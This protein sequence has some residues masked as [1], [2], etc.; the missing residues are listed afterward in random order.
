MTSSSLYVSVEP[1]QTRVASKIITTSKEV[2]RQTPKW[3]FPIG[4]PKFNSSLSRVIR[5][6]SFE[7][8]DRWKYLQD[9]ERAKKYRKL[10]CLA[11]MLRL[12]G[13]A[14]GCNQTINVERTNSK[15]WFGLCIRRLNPIEK[16]GRVIPVLDAKL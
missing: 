2:H 13:G 12:F 8:A 11:V 7:G 10:Q 5:L 16:L 4:C 14:A 6:G 1:R 15:K 3:Q 9:T